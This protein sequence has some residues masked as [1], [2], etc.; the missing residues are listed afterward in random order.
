MKRVRVNG[1]DDR[2]G[3]FDA[4]P[5]AGR[6]MALEN[7]RTLPLQF[8]A[9]PP[10]PLNRAQLG[11][12]GAPV[13]IVRGARTRPCHRIVADAAARCIPGAKRIVVPEARHLWPVHS[14][15]AF[16]D[17]LL[18]CLRAADESRD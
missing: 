7:A 4:M 3:T 13:A 6:T 10:L 16:N 5:A 17:L 9:S 12:I 15:A 2:P 8:A 18:G 11:E 14:P 1:V